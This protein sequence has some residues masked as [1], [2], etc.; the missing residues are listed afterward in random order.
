MNFIWSGLAYPHVL[1]LH[2]VISVISMDMKESHLIYMYN[3]LEEILHCNLISNYLYR[4]SHCS[5]FY[6]SQWELKMT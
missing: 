2:S 6:R 4:D 3:V 1:L 5:D